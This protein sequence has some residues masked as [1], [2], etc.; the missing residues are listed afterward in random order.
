MAFDDA[1]EGERRRKIGEYQRPYIEAA[2]QRLQESEAF[3]AITPEQ[4]PD[5]FLGQQGGHQGDEG[6]P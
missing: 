2:I 6:H 4:V 3:M 1:I 5:R